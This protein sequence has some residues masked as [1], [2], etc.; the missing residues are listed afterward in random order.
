MFNS[1]TP[2]SFTLHFIA[3]TSQILLDWLPYNG[4]CAEYLWE[5]MGSVS[6]LSPQNSGALYAI[7]IGLDRG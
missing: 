3:T 1:S 5:S 7:D 4:R 2:A 6:E